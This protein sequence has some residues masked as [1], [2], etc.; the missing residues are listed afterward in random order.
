M[1]SDSQS[2]LLFFSQFLE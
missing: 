1:E 2:P